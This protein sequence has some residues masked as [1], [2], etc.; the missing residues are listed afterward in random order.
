MQDNRTPSEHVAEF[1]NAPDDAL[2]TQEILELVVQKSGAWFEKH[3]W[4][5]TGIP[6]TRIGRKPL[7]QKRDVLRVLKN[8]RVEQVR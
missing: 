7:Y 2:F 8:N 3:R 5:G 1:W 6:Y 4:A